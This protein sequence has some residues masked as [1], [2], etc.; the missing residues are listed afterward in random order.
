MITRLFRRRYKYFRAMHSW[1]WAVTTHAATSKYLGGRRMPLFPVSSYGIIWLIL[2]KKRF[3]YETGVGLSGRE[4]KVSVGRGNQPPLQDD[5]LWARIDSNPRPSS[6]W[7]GTLPLHQEA[8]S[9]EEGLGTSSK[10]DPSGVSQLV[11]LVKER[12]KFG[13]AVDRH[14]DIPL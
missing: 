7:S 1:G 4:E 12:W 5:W 14:I 6:V 8:M 2:K 9:N 13:S 10:P 11:N 3:A